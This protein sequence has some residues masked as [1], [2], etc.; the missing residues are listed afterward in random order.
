MAGQFTKMRFTTEKKPSAKFKG[1]KLLKQIEGLFRAGIQFQNLG[2]VKEAVEAGERPEVGKLPWGE[3]VNYP[4]VIEHKGQR[5]TRLYPPHARDE[6]G[7]LVASWK[8]G[9]LKVTYMIDG[10]TVS[11]EDFEALLNPSD[12]SKGDIPDCFT[13]KSDN[14]VILS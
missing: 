7:K 4:Y 5:Y 6:N 3:W 13:V 12:R 9:Q 10:Q 11:K 8:A 14:L 1:R 2:A